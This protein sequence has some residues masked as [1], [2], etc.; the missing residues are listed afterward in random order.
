MIRVLNGLLLANNRHKYL[1]APKFRDHLVLIM[2]K[3]NM[4]IIKFLNENITE[5]C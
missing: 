1:D 5:I 4:L 2:L 3:H